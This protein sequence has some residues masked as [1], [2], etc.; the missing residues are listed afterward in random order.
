MHIEH[1]KEILIYDLKP[2]KYLDFVAV[3]LLSDSCILL[4]AKKTNQLLDRA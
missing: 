2:W 1:S 4:L 3:V